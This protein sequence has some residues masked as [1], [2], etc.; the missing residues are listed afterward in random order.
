[1]EKDSSEFNTPLILIRSGESSQSDGRG[2]AT[3]GTLP[4]VA[5]LK[6]RKQKIDSRYRNFCNMVIPSLQKRQLRLFPVA[7]TGFAIHA[8]VIFSL[9]LTLKAPRLLQ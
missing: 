2:D 3:R 1:L 7:S 8:S 4:I 5:F 9:K 6:Y